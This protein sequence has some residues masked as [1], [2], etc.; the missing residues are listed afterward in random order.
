MHIAN[1]H[2]YIDIQLPFVYISI[3]YSPADN[4]ATFLNY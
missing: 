2:Y 4:S 3:C 1:S